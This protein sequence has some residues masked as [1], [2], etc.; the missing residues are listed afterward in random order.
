[1]KSQVEKPAKTL[2]DFVAFVGLSCRHLNDEGAGQMT[3]FFYLSLMKIFN[4]SVREMVE[5]FEKKYEKGFLEEMRGYMREG[6]SATM[7]IIEQIYSL[8]DE[9]G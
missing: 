5:T 8:E 4:D 2:I 7:E 9:N 3:A 6:Q 1:M